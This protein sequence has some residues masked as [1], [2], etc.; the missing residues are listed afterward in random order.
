MADPDLQIGGGGGGL[1]DPEIRGTRLGFQKTFFRPFGAKFG[2]KMKGGGA[3]G[4][5]DPSP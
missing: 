3:M 1:P 5:P 4:S 2:L